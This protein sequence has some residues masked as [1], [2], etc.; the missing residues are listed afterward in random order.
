VGILDKIKNLISPQQKKDL[1]RVIN[2]GPASYSQSI[3]NFLGSFLNPD[4]VGLETYEKMLDT[5]ETVSYGVELLTL[6]TIAR[7]G[8]YSHPD[9]KIN[10]FIHEQFERLRGT[11]YDVAEEIVYS[12]IWAGFALSEM[13]FDFQDDQIVLHDI[14]PINP[15]DVEFILE[16][17]GLNKNRVKS[18]KFYYNWFGGGSA[19]A[20]NIEGYDISKFIHLVGRSRYGNPY[21]ISRL[22]SIYS[23][24]Y[25]KINTIAFWMRGMEGHGSP[26]AEY[27]FDNL[28]NVVVDPNGK[29]ITGDEHIQK[30]M[31]S[32]M[33]GTSIS[34]PKGDELKIHWP[35]RS[36]GDIF[37]QAIQY[38]NQMIFRGLLIP[39]LVAANNEGGSGSYSQ[40]KTHQDSFYLALEKIRRGLTEC[41]IE[42]L[43]RPLIT[44]NF[45]EQ[46]EWGDF[47]CDEFDP[48]TGKLIM[49]MFT[50]AINSG[51]M[52]PDKLEDL[53][54]MRQKINAP[55]IGEAE[56]K[57]M[58]DEKRAE[59]ER[60]AQ[61]IADRLKL[62]GNNQGQN[63]NHKSNDTD[64]SEKQQT[65]ENPSEEQSPK[66]FNLLM[67]NVKS[68]IMSLSEAE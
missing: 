3:F 30:I 65:D 36:F 48:E 47:Q 15:K 60:K 57:S 56:M 5:D 45:G 1:S 35:N 55:E 34:H 21:G 64:E 51:I 9:P 62:P 11:I 7:L 27:I 18:V 26:L 29:E 67:N 23:V 54:H 33:A 32:I 50:G 63:D 13:I 12:S 16:S 43:I 59:D 68:D 14:Q 4:K 2:S 24:Y 22:K 19:D 17:E 42:Q 61:E 8:E 10:D 37:Y 66:K 39:S 58:L 44:W 6:A 25:E 40:S 28:N 41:L 38:F 46:D 53:K 31:A 49:E 20:S 52:F